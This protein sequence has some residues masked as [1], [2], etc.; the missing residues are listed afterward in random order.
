MGR[1]RKTNQYRK[2]GTKK[3][4]KK[5][6]ST[7]ENQ[8]DL[9]AKQD[10]HDRSDGDDDMIA[11]L[12]CEIATTQR[13]QKEAGKGRRE[14]KE[15]KRGGKGSEAK[16]AEMRDTLAEPKR[17][18]LPLP[19]LSSF[20][21]THSSPPPRGVVCEYL[22]HL[23]HGPSFSC[24]GDTP[25]DTS[26]RTSTRVCDRPDPR[27]RASCRSRLTWGA[28]SQDPRRRGATAQTAVNRAQR[29]CHDPLATPFM[30]GAAGPVRCSS[31][32]GG[33]G[34]ARRRERDLGSS[35]RTG[36][37]TMWYV[38][39]SIASELV[40]RPLMGGPEGSEPGSPPRAVDCFR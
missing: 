20:A 34:N 10:H 13:R 24:F 12:R 9:D 22:P 38:S 35:A 19:S 30:R 16:Q 28:P 33:W 21:L 1:Y 25:S 6:R 23:A 18:S 3:K 37:S 39:G 7:K 5:K 36:L 27:A 32:V 8:H 14:E 2:K 40:A 11:E 26:T 17:R 29:A 31:D 15:R 4:K